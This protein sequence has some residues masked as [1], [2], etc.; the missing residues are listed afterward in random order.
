MTEFFIKG[1]SGMPSDKE[2]ADVVSQMGEATVKP[3]H[4]SE[5]APPEEITV[6]WLA[7]FIHEMN[8][9]DLLN[10]AYSCDTPGGRET[11]QMACVASGLKCSECQRPQQTG[12][13]ITP[14]WV[15]FECS[16]G[17]DR[18]FW[19]KRGQKKGLRL[20]KNL[21]ALPTSAFV[22]GGTASGSRLILPFN[23]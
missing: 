4:A 1:A 3:F 14:T 6:G 7:K 16:A 23:R 19:V 12:I 21:L 20:I 9:K 18:L 13:I 2:M 11:I 15:G 8:P 5:G 22:P 10:Q 17:C